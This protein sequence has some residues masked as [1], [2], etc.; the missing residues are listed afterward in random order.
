MNPLLL[1]LLLA[2]VNG[3]P[4]QLPDPNTGVID[5]RTAVLVMPSRHS[6]DGKSEFVDPSGCTAHFVP[7]GDVTTELER[8]CGQWLRLPADSYKVWV[9]GRD[10]IS[11]FL[12]RL[13]Y[14][15]EPFS[16]RGLI[17]AIPVVP[18]GSV[19]LRQ[20]AAEPELSFR[21]LSLNDQ[22]LGKPSLAFD[23]RVQAQ[24]KVVSMPAGRALAGLFDRST[25]DAIALSRP[26]AVTTS[27]IAVAE[28]KRPAGSAV[29]VALQRP[30]AAHAATIGIIL[31][32]ANGPRPPDVH[33]SAIDA[34]YAVW[35]DA[36][37]RTARLEVESS[38]LHLRDV[39]LRLRPRAITTYRG[40]LEMRPKLDVRIEAPA[41]AF[42]G[43]DVNFRRNDDLQPFQRRRVVASDAHVS[44]SVPPELITVTVTAGDWDFERV[45]DLR[46]FAD[47]E[48]PFVLSPI[49]VRGV[50]YAGGRRAKGTV[51]FELDQK[52]VTTAETDE[53]G[54]Y[55]AMLWEPN[56]Y[57]A[58]V[59]VDDDIAPPFVDPVVDV[60]RSRALDFHVPLNRIVA[61]VQD[62]ATG[63]PIPH[64]TVG[65]TNRYDDPTLQTI[66][67]SEPY[68]SGEDGVVRLPPLRP[69]KVTLWATASG[70]APSPHRE[71]D[72]DADVRSEVVLT[73]RSIRHAT[74]EIRMENGALADGAEACVF[75]GPDLEQVV[76]CG[77]ADARGRI[78]VPKEQPGI[79]VIRHPSAASA[80]FPLATVPDGVVLTRPSVQP[81]L[82]RAR[83]SSGE[84]AP[85]ALVTV[86]LGDVR[87]TGMS[88]A[89]AGFSHAIMTNR[90]GEWHARNLPASPVRVLA[91]RGITPAQ[92]ATGAYDTFAVMVAHPWSS[93]AVDLRIAQ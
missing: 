72:V 58:R 38:D 59:R 7:S 49:F 87:V 37:G 75:G 53:A 86:W 36:A 14:A 30:L 62:E 21:L 69:G 82:I 20:D 80:A 26:F 74:V 50:L 4:A 88:A 25:G 31:H 64:A 79:V 12:W 19:K 61:R 73:L 67:I 43:F 45:V 5:G 32:D 51:A 83:D 10:Y 56:V 34:L 66:T 9:E 70:F 39:E 23:R 93:R 15:D 60:E 29:F 54:A 8:P 35:Y 40:R 84:V 18:S 41:G 85:L 33:V 63:T 71:V 77:R 46:D 48:I 27:G 52:T 68:T 1:A 2:A 22:F 76:W 47:H 89:Y 17:G 13:R 44:V 55:E 81:L 3:R 65:V 78:A 57:V 16:G 92:V 24:M 6:S 90:N 91:A 42:A 11:P 28:P